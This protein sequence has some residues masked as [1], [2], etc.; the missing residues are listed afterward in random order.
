MTDDHHDPLHVD[1]AERLL[2]P[3]YYG[4]GS[5]L[6]MSV[7]LSV[8]QHNR[9][10][11][12]VGGRLEGGRFGGDFLT[13]DQVLASSQILPAMRKDIFHVLSEADFRL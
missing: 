10:S 12:S 4:D 13:G 6:E 5:I 11:I 3:R 9:C 8:L 1:T 2:S 7:A